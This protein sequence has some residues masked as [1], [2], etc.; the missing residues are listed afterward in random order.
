MLW[1]WLLLA[2][3]GLFVIRFIYQEWTNPLNSLPGPRGDPLLGVMRT[4]INEP[5]MQ[6]HLRWAK[7]F[8]SPLIHYKYDF[9]VQILVLFFLIIGKKIRAARQST[10]R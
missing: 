8:K 5:P 6:P 2:V 10:G 3:I 7:E 4:I 1:A 9:R